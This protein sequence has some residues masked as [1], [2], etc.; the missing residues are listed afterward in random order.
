MTLLITTKLLEDE[1]GAVDP[2]RLFGADADANA[3]VIFAD[4]LSDRFDAVVPCTA[5]AFAD[6]DLAEVNVELIMHDHCFIGVNF[7][8]MTDRLDGFPTIVHERRGLD[9]NNP[10]FAHLT[11]RHMAFEILFVDPWAHLNRLLDKSIKARKADVVARP[12]VFFAD[13]AEADN[14]HIAVQ[15]DGSKRYGVGCLGSSLE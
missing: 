3:A 15:A 11:G 5:A 13:V 2:G 4:M 8:K 7:I 9:G 1:V 12:V 14:Q 6:T 10:G